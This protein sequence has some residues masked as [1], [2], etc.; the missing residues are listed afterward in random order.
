[1]TH[2]VVAVVERFGEP[3]AHFQGVGHQHGYHALEA[4]F[5]EIGH[6]PFVAEADEEGGELLDVVGDFVAECGFSADETRCIGEGELVSVEI[7]CVAETCD[8]I[9]DVSTA[10]ESV[11]HGLSVLKSC[12]LHWSSGLVT[13]HK[14]W[15]FVLI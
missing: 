2:G 3:L 5:L 1:M 13:L 12:H 9:A 15:I 10:R 4:V 8:E 11:S 6:F 7:F 14:S